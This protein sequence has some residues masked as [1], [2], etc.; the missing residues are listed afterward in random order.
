MSNITANEVFTSWQQLNGSNWPAPLEADGWS[1]MYFDSVT[2]G[3]IL[4]DILYEIPES[5]KTPQPM[6]D[7]ANGFAESSSS[8]MTQHTQVWRIGS[9]YNASPTGI[10]ANPGGPTQGSNSSAQGVL[11]QTNQHYHYLDHGNHGT[12]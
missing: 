5:G 10:P 8:L 2:N 6:N 7:G 11:V 12:R 3:W 1:D 4:V 9:G